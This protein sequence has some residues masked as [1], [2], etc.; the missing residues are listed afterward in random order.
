MSCSLLRHLGLYH[1]LVLVAS[2]L[3]VLKTVG[4]GCA[5]HKTT[6]TA[7]ERWVFNTHGKLKQHV[8]DSITKN[9]IRINAASVKTSGISIITS[10]LKFLSLL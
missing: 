2:G 4:N 1:G 5:Q 9:L 6:S 10:A 3:A 7:A 8:H